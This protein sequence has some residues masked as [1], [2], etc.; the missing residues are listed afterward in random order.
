LKALL[1]STVAVLALALPIIARACSMAGCLDRGI[2]LR[3]DFTVT[4][5]HDGKPLSGVT[6]QVRG[7]SKEIPQLFSNQT[8]NNGTAHFTSL[9]P[10]D[11]WLY[12]DLLGI[13]AGSECFH[14]NSHPS[15]KSKRILH[16]DWGDEAPAFLYAAGTFIDSQPGK[17][18]SPLQN[19]FHRIQVPVAEAT[20]ELRGPFTG[21]VY[22]TLSDTK[23]RFN[24]EGVPKGIYVLSIS[25]GSSDLNVEGILVRF[26]DTAK[27][28]RISLVHRDAG[29]GSC[30]GT[31]FEWQ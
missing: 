9:P 5:K 24:F 13:S 27:T 30:G 16:Y 22:R 25:A 28:S 18:G 10:G 23:G 21:E 29:G 12:S 15:R 2:E 31:G 4:I 26:A 11:Y 7:T 6:V 14:I 1:V 17:G 8:G 20:V 19:R 3:S